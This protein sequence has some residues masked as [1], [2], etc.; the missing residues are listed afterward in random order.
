MPGTA[1]GSAD[2]HA[3]HCLRI[4]PA[5][6]ETGGTGGLHR[7]EPRR[8]VPPRTD[9]T[10]RTGLVMWNSR[11]LQ[12]RAEKSKPRRAYMLPRAASEATQQPGNELRS[13]RLETRSL[14]C[15][16]PP[17][18]AADCAATDAVLHGTATEGSIE[19]L[20]R[21]IHLVGPVATLQGIW[22]GRTRQAQ[23][24]RSTIKQEGKQCTIFIATLNLVAM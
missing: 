3:L 20:M 14:K 9:G 2:E 1:G 11:A 19:P 4:I 5:L 21:R 24:R 18:C 6:F 15:G 8:Q 16:N 17:G 13:R 7:H 12:R 22:I 10:A 23:R